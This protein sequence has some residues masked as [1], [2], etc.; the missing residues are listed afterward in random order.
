MDLV[1]W[2][3]DA[4]SFDGMSGQPSP[5]LWP[6]RGGVLRQPAALVQAVRLLRN[7]WPYVMAAGRPAKRK[8]PEDEAEPGRPG[9]G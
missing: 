7:E 9:I 4:T 8:E 1:E 5:P 3:L 2:W 6:F